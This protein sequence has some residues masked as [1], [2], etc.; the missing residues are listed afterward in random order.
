MKKKIIDMDIRD[1]KKLF[2][3][4]RPSNWG[5][6]LDID[7]YMDQIVGYMERQHIG[8]RVSE[9]LTGAM[10]NNYVKQ[11]IMPKASGKKYNREHVAYLTAICLLKQIVPVKDVGY[12]LENQISKDTTSQ[13]YKKYVSVL[14]EKLTLTNDKIDKSM[15]NDEIAELALELAISSYTQK[16]ACE[17]L[18]NYINDKD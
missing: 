15:T 4:E 3:E 7:L 13:F 9:N 16:L 12:L 2:G 11:N 18:L 6:I 17:C 8:F 10:V 5:D 14:D 1:I